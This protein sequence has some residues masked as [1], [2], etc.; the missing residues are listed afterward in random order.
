MGNWE[1]KKVGTTREDIAEELVLLE[2]SNYDYITNIGEIYRYSDDTKLY[3]KRKSHTNKYN[4]YEYVS[5]MCKVDNK[6]KSRRLHVLL[7][8]TFLENPNNYK[9]VGHKNN[10]KNDNRLNN[11][12]WTTNQENTQKAFDDKLNQPKMGVEN[13]SSFQIAVIENNEIVAVYG[14]MGECARHIENLSI[15]YLTKIVNKN[16]N[17]KPRNKKY[18]YKRISLE[19]YLSIEDKF[20]NVYLTEIELTKQ[21]TLFKATNI[22]TGTESIFDNQKEFAKIHNLSQAMVSHAILNNDI[23][24][25]FKFELIK[26]LDYSETTAYDNFMKTIKGISIQNINTNEVRNYNTVMNLKKDLGL[27]GNDIRQYIIRDN[28]LMNEW[29]VINI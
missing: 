19:D 13:K 7:A 3:Y 9:I 27:K 17:Y 12:Y 11:L 24:S 4:G 26:R 14:S 18:L 20:K 28:I 21:Q 25:G 8:K 29:K 15:G 5:I 1:S 2:E 23:Y 22:E 10:I 6:S 16:G